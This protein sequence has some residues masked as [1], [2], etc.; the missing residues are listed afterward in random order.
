LIVHQRSSKI[1]IICNDSNLKV[2][3]GLSNGNEIK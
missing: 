2:F 1:Y 3:D